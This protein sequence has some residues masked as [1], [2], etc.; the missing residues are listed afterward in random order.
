MPEDGSHSQST[1]EPRCEK[2][3]M[4]KDEFESACSWNK[5]LLLLDILELETYKTSY[6]QNSNK[7]SR[8]EAE[9][10]LNKFRYEETHCFNGFE[11]LGS[12]TWNLFCGCESRR[13]S[14]YCVC[15]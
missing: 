3:T 15:R 1:E 2:A 8:A 14:L 12:S 5:W 13:M 9:K 10:F 4:N 11:K 7:E 6:L